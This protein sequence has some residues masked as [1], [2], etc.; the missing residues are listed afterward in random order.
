MARYY[1]LHP[2][3]AQYFFQAGFNKYPVF[4][5]FFQPYSLM[6]TISWWLF[7]HCRLF[8]CV[9]SKNNIEN[10]I[11]EQ[12]I[13]ELIGEAI[14]AFNMGTPGPEQKVTALGVTPYGSVFVKYG[15]TSTAKENIRNEY[16]TL[17]QLSALEFVPQVLDFHDESESVLLKTS[18]FHGD[19]IQRSIITQD[20]MARLLQLSEVTYEP[21][22]I[23]ET[24]LRSC[25]AHGDF[26]PW[27]MMVRKGELLLF[28]WEM[29]GSYPLGYDLFTFMFQTSFLLSPAKRIDEILK[30]NNSVIQYYFS[31]MGVNN[32]MEYLKEFA[33]VK[34]L[35]ESRKGNKGLLNPYSEL[36]NY[37]TEA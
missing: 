25:F 15:K 1:F 7:R 27:N 10:Y 11:P 19:R 24:S 37:V 34:M 12:K 4:K 6:G 14:M 30:E 23:F 13:R 22:R 21:G 8:R 36:F 3:K 26:C 33:S 35:L 16:H 20:I 5:T 18:V 17:R 29:A 9:F 32:S 28:D 31:R 2:F